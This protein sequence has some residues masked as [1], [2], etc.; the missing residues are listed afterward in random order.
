[1]TVKKQE[2]KKREIFSRRL[3]D[4]SGGELLYDDIGHRKVLSL[5]NT[6]YQRP[7]WNHRANS[8]GVRLI[9]DGGEC[10]SILKSKTE[11]KE[12]MLKK[13]TTG[14][15]KPYAGRGRGRKT[16]HLIGSGKVT[17]FSASETR[18]NRGKGGVHYRARKG[19]G[20]GLK[21]SDDL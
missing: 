1:V 11:N 2:T 21:T 9:D 20:T 8:R 14:Q 18:V 4:L 15:Q 10:T 3:K 6:N 16:R 17:L 13:K 12:A 7:P 5:E 19:K